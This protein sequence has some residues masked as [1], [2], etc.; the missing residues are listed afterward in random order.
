ML[1]MI[2]GNVGGD[3][4]KR[5]NTLLKGHWKKTGLTGD[6][7]PSPSHTVSKDSVSPSSRVDRQK[8]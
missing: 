4:I 2:M 3:K 8:L 7:A 6:K 1:I 5:A